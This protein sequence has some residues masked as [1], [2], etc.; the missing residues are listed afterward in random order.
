MPVNNA[1]AKK[2]LGRA[3]KAEESEEKKKD[4]DK[5]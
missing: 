5:D 4:K 2:L 3:P 1:D